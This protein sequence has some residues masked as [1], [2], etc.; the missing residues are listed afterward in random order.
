MT[1]NNESSLSYNNETS[2]SCDYRLV[3]VYDDWTR[4]TTIG[5]YEVYYNEYGQPAARSINPCRIVWYPED[6]T[7]GV[8]ARINQAF[9]K[10][11][12]T[13]DDFVNGGVPF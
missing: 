9:N 1:T 8:N 5:I 2:S 7:I 13:D 6:S 3:K 11:I 10:S 4:E 12:L